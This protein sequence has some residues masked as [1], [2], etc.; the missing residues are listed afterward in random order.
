VDVPV[1]LFGGLR[2]YLPAGS[3]FNSCVIQ[4]EDGTTLDGLLDKVPVPRDKPYMVMLNDTKI[5]EE[6]FGDTLI[7]EG[8]DL[9]LLPPIKGG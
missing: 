3:G 9:V 1:K 2:H 7:N 8:D 5:S 4:V 6:Q